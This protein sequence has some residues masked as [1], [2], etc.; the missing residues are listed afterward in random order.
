MAI[1]EE[2]IILNRI[3]NIE[4]ELISSD[5]EYAKNF[6]VDEGFNIEQEIDFSVKY[7]AKVKFMAQA[8]ANKNRDQ[9]LLE[10]A[11]IKI[12]EVIQ[13]NSN[14]ASVKLAALLQKRTPLVQYRKLE[15]WSDE[16][17]KEVLADVDLVK[18]LEELSNKD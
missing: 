7:I 12:K 18:L 5:T 3:D 4:L 17:I 8:L 16:E 2:D 13:E 11:F 6:L 9:H 14:L 1:K 15:K 10:K